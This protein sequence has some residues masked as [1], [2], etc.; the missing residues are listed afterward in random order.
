LAKRSGADNSQDWNALAFDLFFAPNRQVPS[1]GI[2][3]G[4]PSRGTDP[5]GA[6]ETLLF[7]PNP[8][9]GATSSDHRGFR[10]PPDYLW[11]DL[12]TMP[13]VEPYAISEPFSTAGKINL[14]YQIVPFTYVT[15]STG[16][17][18]VLAA[19]RVSA[20]SSNAPVTTGTTM[21]Y[22]IHADET[23]KQ[24]QAK[25][26]SN[27]I[28][29][30][31]AE[32]CSMWLYPANTATPTTAL[33]TDSAGSSSGIQNWWYG[34]ADAGR[35]FTGDNLREQPYTALYQN[36]TTQA[37]TYTVHVYVQALDQ[38][39][40][41]KLIVTGEYRGSYALE[42]FLDPKS[43]SLPDFTSATSP[44]AMGYYQFRVNNTT[45]FLP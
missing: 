26:D 38:T 33:A 18:A 3:G 24:F 15:R 28:F 13:I 7:C 10:S 16:M 45:Q 37:N 11:M 17:R 25:F 20:I 36:L 8:A 21:R 29:K 4:L 9:A 40:S 31:A 43:P 5:N 2:M 39:P 42:R 22:R 35:K 44:N 32:I 27:M 34:G 19:N 23:L 14:N 12:F 1:P 6:W 41:G 30:S